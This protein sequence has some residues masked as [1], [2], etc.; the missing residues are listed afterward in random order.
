MTVRNPRPPRLTA[1]KGTGLRFRAR[2]VASRVPS[3]P[4]TTI[5]STCAGISL[6]VRLFSRISRV[7][8]V[9][10]SIQDSIWRWRS[11]SMSGGTISRTSVFF[12]LE[13][14]PI[15]LMRIVHPPASRR[16]PA[17][18][19]G[20][21]PNRMKE[22]LAIAGG[23]RQHALGRSQIGEAEFR[24]RS[25][26]LGHGLLMKARVAHHASLAHLD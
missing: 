21:S 13:V 16:R 12:G 9:S 25:P 23:A 11:H 26:D 15:F 20:F 18:L 1:S 14:T 6:R 3:P 22:K 5:R 7:A 2:A 17:I 8:A 24:Q 4:S 10:L 19:V